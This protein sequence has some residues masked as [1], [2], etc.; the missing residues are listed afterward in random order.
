MEF[1]ATWMMLY[2]YRRPRERIGAA[3]WLGSGPLLP[4]TRWEATNEK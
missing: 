2:P 1:E 3:I 4:K